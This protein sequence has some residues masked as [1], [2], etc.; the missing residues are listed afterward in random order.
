MKNDLHK[1]KK[2]R[3]TVIGLELQLNTLQ[4]EMEIAEDNLTQL[5]MMEA[6]LIENI[7]VLRK[8]KIVAMASEYRKSVDGLIHV[9]K[10]IDLWRNKKLVLDRKLEIK[11]KSYQSYKR[12]F[13]TLKKQLDNRKVILL[14]N[15]KSRKK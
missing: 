14:F 1:L 7:D 9:R 11:Q 13:D 15:P 8:E 4:A 3:D 10:K 5:Y 2:I 12:D 6:E